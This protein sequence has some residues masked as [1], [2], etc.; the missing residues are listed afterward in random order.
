MRT[1]H[2]DNG[3]SM[4][5]L[6][7]SR[8]SRANFDSTVDPGDNG[9]DRDGGCPHGKMEYRSFPSSRTVTESQPSAAS[10]CIRRPISLPG[11]VVDIS[12]NVAGPRFSVL[13]ACS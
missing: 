6:V 7:A 12:D 10:W 13:S 4:T 3:C 5:K 11:E 9:A 8:C 1:S 2:H